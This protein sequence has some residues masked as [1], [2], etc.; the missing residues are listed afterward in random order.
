MGWM[1]EEMR[2]LSVVVPCY[3]ELR[4][5][6]KALKALHACDPGMPMEIIV[7][8]DYSTDGTRDLLQ[9]TLRPFVHQ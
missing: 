2:T 7:V 9:G 8:D 5:I 1:V 6:E 4:T 3:N